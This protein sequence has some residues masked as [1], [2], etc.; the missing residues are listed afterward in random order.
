MRNS[1]HRFGFRSYWM[2]RRYIALHDQSYCWCSWPVGTYVSNWR[3]RKSYDLMLF[4]PVCAC[5][6]YSV[7]LD[8]FLTLRHRPLHQPIAA[9][10]TTRRRTCIVVRASFAPRYQSYTRVCFAECGGGCFLVLF[11]VWDFR[12]H[13][14]MEGT[15]L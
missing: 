10:P 15:K 4:M 9:R 5:A 3:E 6:F 8:V 2:A 13:T 11:T 1:S 12:D 14:K 7:I